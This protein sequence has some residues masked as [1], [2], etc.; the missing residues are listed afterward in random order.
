MIKSQ[1]L[2]SNET[3]ATALTFYVVFSYLRHNGSSPDVLQDRAACKLVVT[4]HRCM[5]GRA[6]D[7]FADNSRALSS[8]ASNCRHIGLLYRVAQKSKP[9]PNDQKILLNRIIAC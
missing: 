8:R 3:E 5:N 1:L 4:V 9:L 6:R 7:Y 2:L